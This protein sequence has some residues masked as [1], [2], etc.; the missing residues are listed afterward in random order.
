MVIVVDMDMAMRIQISDSINQVFLFNINNSIQYLL[1]DYVHL[2]GFKYYYLT[3]LSLFGG[4][5]G[6]MVM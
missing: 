6:V 1:F 2:N 4:A 5:R 3:L